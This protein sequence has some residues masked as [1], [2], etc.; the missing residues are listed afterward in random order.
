MGRGTVDVVFDVYRQHC[1]K[2]RIY[3]L[4]GFWPANFE[5]LKFHNFSP[6]NSVYFF[7]YTTYIVKNVV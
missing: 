1:L 5:F 4:P 2:Y 3:I 7:N 6:M